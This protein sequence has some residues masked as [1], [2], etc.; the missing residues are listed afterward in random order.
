MLKKKI[1]GLVV[2]CHK[3]KKQEKKQANKIKKNLKKT[4]KTTK[5]NKKEKL[6]IANCIREEQYHCYNLWLIM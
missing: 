5:Q 6:D 2:N 1:A 4:D 3:S